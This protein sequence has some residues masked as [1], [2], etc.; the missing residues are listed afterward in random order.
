MILLDSLNVV[1]CVEDVDSDTVFDE[2]VESD[3]DND[4]DVDALND[5]VYE[6]DTV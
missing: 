5:N 2:D 4:V 3:N 6:S 1:D